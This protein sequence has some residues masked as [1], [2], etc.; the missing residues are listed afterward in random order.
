MSNHLDED[1]F[2]L[3]IYQYPV[4]WD[5]D[6][7]QSSIIELEETWLKILK[8]LN[9]NR[10]IQYLK[11]RYNNLKCYYLTYKKR[12]KLDKIYLKYLDM[13]F[14]KKIKK[15]IKKEIKLE[16]IKS[17][18]KDNTISCEL[19][20]IHELTI[21]GVEE[22]QIEEVAAFRMD[23]Y[24]FQYDNPSID[25]PMV[26]SPIENIIQE[27]NPERNS[28]END[29]DHE[30]F[31]NFFIEKSSNC[32]AN[33]S[34]QAIKYLFTYVQELFM[35]KNDCEQIKFSMAFVRLIEDWK[36]LPEKEFSDKYVN[37]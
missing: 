21:P 29:P 10:T 36:R 12:N 9:I 15:E 1:K 2:I 33:T 3:T 16:P 13:M 32:V 25:A 24:S 8:T 5:K 4:I 23:D 20:P 18:L 34:P 37:H 22:E 35:V 30:E 14:S 17:E 6:H 26:M 11:K 7:F 28:I 27:N 31:L 19:S